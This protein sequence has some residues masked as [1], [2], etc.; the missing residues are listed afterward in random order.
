METVDEGRMERMASGNASS[1][2]DEDE[3]GDKPA[4]QPNSGIVIMLPSRD[5]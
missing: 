1:H 4:Q 3:D 5:E 2:Q